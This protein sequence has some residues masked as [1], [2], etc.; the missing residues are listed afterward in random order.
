MLHENTVWLMK[1]ISNQSYSRKGGSR[2]TT[3]AFPQQKALP[4]DHIKIN[5]TPCHTLPSSIIHKY[6]RD[7]VFSQGVKTYLSHSYL[8]H[9]TICR[10]T[11]SCIISH[12]AGQ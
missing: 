9:G 10:I 3:L 1:I 6:L 5:I 12:N 2:I 4:R 8:S 11:C 7:L